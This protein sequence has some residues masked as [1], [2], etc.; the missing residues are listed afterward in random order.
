MIFSM[1]VALP[2]GHISPEDKNGKK[3]SFNPFESE[4]PFWG[5]MKTVQTQFRCHKIVASDQDL[6]CFYTEISM[7]I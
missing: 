4:Y 6:H 5:I 7:E 3:S 2:Q 1:L